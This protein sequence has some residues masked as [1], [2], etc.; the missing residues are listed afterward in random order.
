MAQRLIIAGGGLSGVLTA[1]AFAERPDVDVTLLEA[2]PTLG[3]DHTWSFYATDVDTVG[4]RLIAPFV[5]HSW[6]GYD[7][8]FRG[9]KRR[10]P[11]PYRTVTSARLDDVARARLGG[12]V[13]FSCPVAALDDRSATLGDGT[14]LEADAVIDA[15]GPSEL[16]GA[17]LRWQ[18]FL[19]REVRL[20]APHGLTRP[21]IMD[22]TVEQLDG[23]RFVY[24]LPY[25]ADTLLIEDTYYAED[26]G[27]DRA[28]LRAR[29]DLYAASRGWTIIGDVREETGVLPLLL[30]GDFSAIWS[31]AAPDG[32][33]APIGVR[34]ALFHPVTSYSLPHA[35]QT[36]VA[37]ATLAGPLSTDR[38]RATVRTLA[39]QHF[40]R[41]GFDRLLNRLLFLA[42]RPDERH[43][44]LERFHRLPQPLIERFYAGRM[45]RAQQ[46]RVLIGKPP[47]PILGALRA[48]P[49]SAAAH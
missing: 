12:K 26:R 20:A 8:V 17:V 22:A 4:A 10:L 34:A 47:V 14:R 2:G 42:G 5:A 1:L 29:I 35:V 27:L 23:Y 16:V 44:V 40:A 43:G 46:A 32:G 13:R 3:G 28:T 36:A 15:R 9:L 39:A 38:V 24:L 37:L 45:S 33:A 48:L 7:V 21:T 30:G 41:S 11:T 18:K 25:S 6:D 49:Q 19:G 31:H